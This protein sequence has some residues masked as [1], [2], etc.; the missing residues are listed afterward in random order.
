MQYR[1]FGLARTMVDDS[2]TSLYLYIAWNPIE[3]LCAEPDSTS[4]YRFMKQQKSR[5]EVPSD[6]DVVEEFCSY[7]WTLHLRV[8]S[9]DWV[10]WRWSLIVS[11]G[12]KT[13][14]GGKGH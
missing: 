9:P 10:D 6:E 5:K 14:L 8:G 11:H 1:A 7:E 13:L 12:N 2:S 3:H 4:R